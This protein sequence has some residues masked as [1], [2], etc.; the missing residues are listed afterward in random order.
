M[1]SGTVKR[2]TILT[3]L[4]ATSP[5]R[6]MQSFA[7]FIKEPGPSESKSQSKEPRIADFNQPI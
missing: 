4:S 6:T 2:A 1:K 7:H 5:K 3:H